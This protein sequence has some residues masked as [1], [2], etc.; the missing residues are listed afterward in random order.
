MENLKLRLGEGEV[1]LEHL[2]RRDVDIAHDCGGVLACTSC[3]VVIREGLEHLQTPS[4]EELDL[5][6]RADS[7]VR[8][9]RL[10]CQVRGAGELVVAIPRSEAPVRAILRP[11]FV[12]ARAAKHLAAQLA[13]HPR[14]LAVRLA[15]Q[16]SGCSGFR[17]RVD[18][19]DAVQEGD[20]VFD[21]GG[22]RIVVDATSLPYVQGTTLDVVEEGLARRLRFDNPNARQSC[23][24]GE[25]FGV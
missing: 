17:Y 24:C 9:E 13:K 3:R 8:N 10:A 19:T 6:D 16:P 14:A 2:L 12:T 15:A 5:L 11:V 25:S 23:G 20:R 1:L 22:V 7:R 18:P 21:S 4:T